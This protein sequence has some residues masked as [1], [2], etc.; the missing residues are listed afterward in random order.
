[1]NSKEK[2]NTLPKLLLIFILCYTSLFAKTIKPAFIL[3]SCGLVNDFVLDSFH[4][5]TATNEGIVEIFDIRIE[6]KVGQILLPSHMSS[7]GKEVP[8]KVLSVDR[9]NNKTLIVSTDING[10]RNV[11]LH[12]GKTLKN[13]VDKSKKL[14]IKEARFINNEEFIYGTLGYDVARYTTNDSSYSVYSEHIEQSAFSDMAMSE[15]KKHMVTASESGRVTLI[16]VKS[17]NILNKFESLNVDN[18]YKLDY[19]NGTIIT[20]GQDRRVGI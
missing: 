4:L 17:G 15:D 1:M 7:M 19:K 14:T 5:Y 20:A 12:D 10:Y 8:S 13:L 2:M 11:W 16:D 6:K 18:I 9:L 3:K